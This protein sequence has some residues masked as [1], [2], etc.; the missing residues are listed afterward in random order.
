MYRSQEFQGP[1][2]VVFCL[3]FCLWG[4]RFFVCFD[5]VFWGIFGFFVCWEGWFFLFVCFNPGL[6]SNIFSRKLFFDMQYIT[7]YIETLKKN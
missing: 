2:A 4:L 7:K 6:G 1:L 5:L 3:F